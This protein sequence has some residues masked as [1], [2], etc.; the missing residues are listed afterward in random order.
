MDSGSLFLNSRDDPEA[1]HQLTG[2]RRHEAHA[3]ALKAMGIEHRL[4]PDGAV[5][6][7]V[8]H[9]EEV[10]G[11]KPRVRAAKVREVAP[12]WGAI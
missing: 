4:R 12:N 10:L 11:G 5:V 6:V 8:A 2:M 3:R 7:S 9:V 1:F